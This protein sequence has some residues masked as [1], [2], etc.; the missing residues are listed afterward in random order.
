[1]ENRHNKAYKFQANRK[2]FTIS[3]Y[4][5]FVILMGLIMWKLIYNWD[6]KVAVTKY[7]I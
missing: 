1:M 7:V 2:Y 3:I 4:A 6:K 5:L